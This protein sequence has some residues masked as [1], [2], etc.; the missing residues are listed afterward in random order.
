MRRLRLILFLLLSLAIPVQGLAQFAL[1][2]K[3]CPMELAAMDMP[4][5]MSL[6]HD[7]CNDPETAAKTGQPCKT[8]QS[9]SSPGQLLFFA[10]IA[11]L[12]QERV[13]SV[14]F[15]QLAEALFSSDPA[16]TWRPP[17]QL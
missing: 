15:P 11:V 4:A 17:A 10:D 6:M 1:Q 14:R 12:Q 3:A 13:A 2:Q 9:C 16:A 8:L 7:C 5:D